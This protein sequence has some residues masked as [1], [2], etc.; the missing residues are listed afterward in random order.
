MALYLEP[1]HGVLVSEKRY[2]ALLEIV[3]EK[4]YLAKYK[5]FLCILAFNSTF[6]ASTQALGKRHK[7]S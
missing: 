3:A 2:F 4:R 1:I 7:C 5:D 6:P